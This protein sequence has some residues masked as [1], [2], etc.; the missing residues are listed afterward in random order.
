M[1]ITFTNNQ[2]NVLQY[3]RTED[4]S[5]NLILLEKTLIHQDPDQI[6]ENTQ[7]IKCSKPCYLHFSYRKKLKIIILTGYKH[8]IS[9]LKS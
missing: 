4:L 5:I 1:F 2:W 6:Q 7:N 8:G 9:V 3:Y